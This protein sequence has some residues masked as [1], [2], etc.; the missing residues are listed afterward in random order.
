MAEP[1]GVDGVS[2]A[3][4][5]TPE[6]PD[7][8]AALLAQANASGTPL[9][10]TGGC[11]KLEWGNVPDAREL[12]RLDVSGL[13][14]TLDVQA[15]EGI[16]TVSAGIRV[17]ELERAARAC[18]KRTRLPTLYAGATVGGTIAAD[19][20]SP[21]PTL[22]GRLRNDLLGLEVAL[23][24]GSRTESGGRVV[25]NVTGFDLVR[26]YCGSLGTLGVITEATLRL[27]P[28]PELCVVCERSFQTL[29][30]AVETVRSIEARGVAPRGIA[31]LVDAAGLRLVWNVEGA[32]ADVEERCTRVEGDRV[33]ASEWS[34]V[35]DAIVAAAN[36]D[37]ERARVRMAARPSDTLAL[38]NALVAHGGDVQLALP[39]LGVVL[40]ELAVRRCD[41]L[42]DTC[43]ADAWTVFVERAAPREKERL[44]VFGPAPAA[45]ELM[46]AL[47]QRFDPGRVLAPGRFM[48]R[49]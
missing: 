25:K 38:A 6:K 28:V 13:N 35:E 37:P 14:A 1:A 11:T 20:L 47:K 46:R 4:V 40:G 31:V 36:A 16:A 33:A 32:K 5:A 34:D 2:F 17:E 15:D 7:D 42:F 30:T 44:D 24:N 18:G 19:P 21:M 49:I 29:D 8:V 23:T 27:W 48:G 41:E 45:I 39:A 26:L 10:V 22:D 43:L 9:V 12:V 3:S